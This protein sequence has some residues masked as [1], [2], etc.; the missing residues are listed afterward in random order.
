[1]SLRSIHINDLPVSFITTQ[2]LQLKQRR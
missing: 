1:M 2:A